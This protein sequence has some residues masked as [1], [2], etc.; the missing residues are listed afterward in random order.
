MSNPYNVSNESAIYQ[1]ANAVTALAQVSAQAHP[2]LTQGYLAIAME[3]SK[4]AGH[5][6]DLVKEIFHIVFPGA[7]PP[8]A[9]SPEEFAAK[10]A[11]LGK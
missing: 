11:E 6:D 4:R 5:G 2:E 1:L 9:L 3:G 8:V 10:Q 7:Q